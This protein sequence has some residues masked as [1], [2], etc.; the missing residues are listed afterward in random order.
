MTP[1]CSRIASVELGRKDVNPSYFHAVAIRRSLLNCILH[2]RLSGP[3]SLQAI[4]C[5]K[6]GKHN[7]GKGHEYTGIESNAAGKTST[8]GFIF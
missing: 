5:C 6:Y 1:Y 3:M 2:T 7:A 8:K 4:S